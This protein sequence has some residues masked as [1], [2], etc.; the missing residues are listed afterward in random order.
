MPSF[1]NFSN[2]INEQTE[3]LAQ[4][5]VEKVIWRMQLE[6]PTWEEEQAVQMFMEFWSFLAESLLDEETRDD[7]DAVPD[8]LLEWSAKNSEM[9]VTSGG[10]INEIVVRYPPTREVFNDIVTRI[11]VEL[12]MSVKENALI[13]KRINA[14]LDISLNETFFSYKRLSDQYK[15]EAQEEMLKLSAPLVPIKDEVVVLPLI[16]EIDSLKVEHIMKN[17]VPSIAE[18]EVDHLIVDFS[19]TLTINEQIAES[20]HQIGNSL[21][22]MGVHVVIT[23]LR[24]ELVQAIVHSNIEI[25]VIDSY[26]T[27]KQAVEHI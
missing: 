10:E 1:L 11:S 7:G 3:A 24:P 18:I 25:A 16:G 27:V 20:L 6:L 22:L 5:V 26:A 13:I 14:M 15:K 8:A 12:D 17:V 4:E 19:G 21:R 23:G 2:Y 9:Q